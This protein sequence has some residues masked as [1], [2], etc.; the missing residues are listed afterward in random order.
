MKLS[1]PW[2]TF[3]HEMEAMFGEDPEISVE[4]DDSDEDEMIIKLYVDN[5]AKAEALEQLLPMEK[6]F[7]NVSVYLEIIPANEEESKIR[8]FQKAFENNPVFKFTYSVP[9]IG[10]L[11]PANYVVFENKV[12]QFFNDELNDI[13]GNK[14]TLYQE[15]AKDIFEDHE[16]IYFCTDTKEEIGKPLG[17]WP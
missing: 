1:A 4:L 3:Y 2:I 11:Y 9:N 8:L 14:S 10:G 7:G 15:I 17:E 16:G 6:K 5:P 13:H 12:V